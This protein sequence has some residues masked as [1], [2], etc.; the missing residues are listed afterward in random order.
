MFAPIGSSIFRAETDDNWYY[1]EM[2]RLEAPPSVTECT[3]FL[4]DATFPLFRATLP[5]PEQSTPRVAYKVDW[6]A[7]RGDDFGTTDVLVGGCPAR[8][9]VATCAELALGEKIVVH[10]VQDLP[11]I[12]EL[13]ARFRSGRRRD[14]SR[15][16]LEHGPRR[17]TR[18]GGRRS[19][20]GRSSCHG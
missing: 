10:R 16:E 15:T 8:P 17:R 1:V 18:G 20:R 19:R 9:G 2:E 7:P 4:Q 11:E 13:A 12:P 5:K 3:E 6:H 14:S